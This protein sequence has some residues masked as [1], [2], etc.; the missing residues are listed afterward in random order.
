MAGLKRRLERVEGLKIKTAVRGA[1]VGKSLFGGEIEEELEG[2]SGKRV[3]GSV[4]DIKLFSKDGKKI[5]TK[6][7]IDTGAYS[8]S[9]DKEL[10]RALGL[11][12][13]IDAFDKIDLSQF[14]EINKKGTGIDKKIKE[15]YKKEIPELASVSITWSSNG[16]TVR[17]M[18][19]IK[20]IMDTKTVI[21]TAN[22]ID[23]SDLKYDMI[24]GKRNL[25]RFLVD[26]S[27]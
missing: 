16:V 19:K 21:T 15:K 17:P 24:I 11:G 10:A 8:T 22:I 7:K 27:K 5:I 25:Y 6:A 9:I 12:H 3:I 26:V 18:V 14:G 20:F 13:V 1:A 2:M 4:E 23:R